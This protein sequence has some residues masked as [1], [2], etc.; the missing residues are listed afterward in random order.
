MIRNYLQ[1]LSIFL[2]VFLAGSAW[3]QEDCFDGV[4]N[5]GDGLIDLNDPDGC[6][7]APSE[8]EEFITNGDFESYFVCPNAISAF[9]VTSELNYIVNGGT[10]DYFNSCDFLG[11]EGITPNVAPLLGGDNGEGIV[12]F[13]ADSEEAGGYREYITQCLVTELLPGVTYTVEFDIATTGFFDP[14]GNT[15]AIFTECNAL[16]IGLFGYPDCPFEIGN[17]NYFGCLSEAGDYI[18][19][20]DVDVDVE[21]FEFTTYSFTF[22]VPEAITSLAIGPGCTEP[23]CTGPGTT[24][25]FYL[26]NYSVTQAATDAIEPPT[27]SVEGNSCEGFTFQADQDFYDDYQWFVDGIAA[28]GEIDQSFE[29]A[30]DLTPSI[31]LG[32]VELDED[33][34]AIC[35]FSNPFQPEPQTEFSAE[36]NFESII[37]PGETTTIDLT[38]NP[39]GEY[40]FN[41]SSG[42]SSSSIEVGIGEYEVEI[43]EVLTG[44][45]S[46]FSY[47]ITSCEDEVL[48]LSLEDQAVCQGESVNL[49]ATVQGDN[50]PFTYTWNPPI[51]EGA[52]PLTVSPQS[53]Q[54]YTLTVTD[55]VGNTASVTAQVTVFDPLEGDFSLG[56]DTIICSLEPLVIGPANPSD[57]VM[58]QWNTGSTEPLIPVTFSGTYELT[59]TTP[60]A[61]FSDDIE[62]N[63][64]DD[65]LPEGIPDTLRYCRDETAE[66][67]LNDSLYFAVFWNDG[68]F[69]GTRTFAEDGVYQVSVESACGLDQRSVVVQGVDCDC[70]IYLPNAF[71]PNADGINDVFKMETLCELETFEIQ[72]FN[73]WGEEV[74]SSTDPEFVWRGEDDGNDYFSSPAVY[75]YRIEAQPRPILFVPEPLNIRGSISVTR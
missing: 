12:G 63:V 2:L 13:Y 42:E 26:D 18:S 1:Y 43:T 22:T 48:F 32:V 31:V 74:F 3:A 62:V 15:S 25:Y 33:G 58:Y 66:I 6:T 72:I 36:A 7:C 60:C 20:L 10:T 41:W 19:L 67:D 29:L 38:V 34:Q 8:G 57:A 21:P 68:V 51:G 70:D 11:V 47:V 28:T 37:C 46:T 73:R 23:T 17:N 4:D 59:A 64:V 27:F 54:S 44:C 35:A 14:T 40:E 69:G 9:P 50:P 65:E 24:N 45:T 16:S 75:A 71:T 53:S 49:T 56:N 39:S 5:D 30:A 55:A 52:G 61:S